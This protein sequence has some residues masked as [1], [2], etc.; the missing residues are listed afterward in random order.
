MVSRLE[1]TTELDQG[2]MS[3]RAAIAVTVIFLVGFV[4]IGAGHF[5]YRKLEGLTSLEGVT[6]HL[7]KRHPQTEVMS[8]ATLARLDPVIEDGTVLVIDVRTPEEFAVSRIPRSLHANDRPS[9][10][11]LLD[12]RDSR[13]DT[14]VLVDATGHRAAERAAELAGEDAFDVTWLG[15]GLFAWANENRKLVDNRGQPVRKVHPYHPYWMRLLDKERRAAV[16]RVR[17]P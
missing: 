17:E 3:R 12:G 13:P 11:R 8:T 9:L 6:S 10:R 4:L 7:R 15:G 1:G 14:V 2:A 16:S 5:G